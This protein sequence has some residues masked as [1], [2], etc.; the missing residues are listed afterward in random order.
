MIPDREDLRAE[1]YRD[2]DRSCD[3]CDEED[4]S[5][6]VNRESDEARCKSCFNNPDTYGDSSEGSADE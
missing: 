6:I 2:P 1:S 3:Y 4:G 5:M